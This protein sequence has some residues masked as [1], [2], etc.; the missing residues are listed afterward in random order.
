MGAVDVLWV[1]ELSLV[2]YAMTPLTPPTVALPPGQQH[3]APGKWPVVGERT[4]SA[5]VGPWAIHCSGVVERDRIWTLDELKSWPRVTRRIDIHCV[6]RWSRLGVEFTGVPL[7]ALLEVCQ[8]LATARFVSFVAQSQRAH[9]TSLPLT[10]AHEADIL[11]AF[12]ADGFPLSSEHGGPV[13][14][15]TPGRY[16]YKSLKWLARIELL[17]DDRLGYWEAMAGYHNGA[18]P[19]H[20]E[21]FLA[22][23]FDLKTVR[24]RIATRDFSQLD[25]RGLMATGMD[26][27]G[28]QAGG[29]KLRDAHFEGADLRGSCFDGANLSGAHLERADL[30]GATFCP[31]SNGIAADL[32][33]ADLRGADLRGAQFLGASLFGAT[34][35]TIDLADSISSPA[36]IDGTTVFDRAAL[37]SLE[38]IPAQLILLRSATI[39]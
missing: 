23:D 24:E 3:V 27:M 14:I 7:S 15:I 31:D 5:P 9:S 6:T 28:L 37:T 1:H 4:A 11:I 8:P 13:R 12:E 2:L 10:V 33:G 38:S 19:W 20:E 30:R 22:P 16:F 35:G 34:F 25:L 17:K 26:L 36:I 32:E 21:R 29:A 39:R 18:R